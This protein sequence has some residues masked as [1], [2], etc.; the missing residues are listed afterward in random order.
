M[1]VPEAVRR[2][3]SAT[4]ASE[5]GVQSLSGGAD[6]REQPTVSER[7]SKVSETGVRNLSGALARDVAAPRV[8]IS[9]A[10][11]PLRLRVSTRFFSRCVRSSDANSTR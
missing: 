10:P 5:S 2:G 4:G 11:R 1:D 3:E 9:P 7:L 6:F 8:E